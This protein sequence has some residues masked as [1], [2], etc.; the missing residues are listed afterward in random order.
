MT[1]TREDVAGKSSPSIIIDTIGHY[2]I[3]QVE[4]QSRRDQNLFQ[5]H[6]DRVG[7][8]AMLQFHV[9]HNR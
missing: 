7:L 8:G 2:V 4:Y 1:M 9:T 6:S 5:L 3:V